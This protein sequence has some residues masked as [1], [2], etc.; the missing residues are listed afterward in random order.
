[1]GP[2]GQGAAGL[3]RAQFRCAAG[4]DTLWPE[5]EGP[6][7]YGARSEAA[8]PLSTHFRCAAGVDPNRA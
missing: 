7:S 6:L 2:A 3:V 5:R 8:G 4:V 1:M